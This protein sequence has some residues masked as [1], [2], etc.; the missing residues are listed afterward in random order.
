MYW[1][2]QDG[3]QWGEGRI[4]G[5]GKEAEYVYMAITENKSKTE[6]L[7]ESSESLH[8]KPKAQHD[9]QDFG[10]EFRCTRAHAMYGTD[11]R[12]LKGRDWVHV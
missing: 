4:G 8:G 7:E 1:E 3:C 12:D 11:T 5:G 10:G 9:D 2:N 6:L